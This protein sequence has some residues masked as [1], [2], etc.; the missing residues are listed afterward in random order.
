MK[1]NKILVL[2][3]VLL[4][5]TALRAEKL[6]RV[7]PP[8]WWIGMET[9]LQL[10]LH[11]KDIKDA[12]VTVDESVK[13]LSI[14]KVT[15]TDNS[16]Y[17]FV[18]VK[19]GRRLNPGTYTFTVNT[20]D[21]RKIEF[22]YEF[23]KRRSYSAR[24]E[25][26]GPADAVYLLMPDRFAN[27]DKKNDSSVQTVEKADPKDLGGRHGGDIQGIIDHLDDIASLGAT[28][29]WSTP[30]LLDDEKSYSYHGYACADYYRIDPRYGSN[31]LYRKFVEKAHS[32]DLKVIMDMVPN[33]CGTAHWWMKDLPSKNWINNPENLKNKGSEFIRSNA[34]MSTQND[35]HVAKVDKESCTK[36]WFDTTMPDMNLADPLVRQYLLQMAV[37]WVEW[38]DLDG[39][40]VDTFPYS[41]ADGIAKWT[42]GIR[43]EYRN[44]NIVGECW[45]GDVASCSYWEGR[46]QRDGYN[47]HLPSVMD[48]P[49]MFATISAL[50]A[51]GTSW[52]PS[53]LRIYNSVAL[54]WLYDDPS[55]ILVFMGNHD[56]PRLAHELGGDPDKIKMA[57][58]LLATMRGVPQL[59]YGDEYGLQSADGTVGHS[60][61]RVDMPWGSFTREQLA[62]RKW[63]A[64]L[65][66]WRKNSAPVTKGGLI[67]FRPDSR[68]VYVYFRTY[69][70]GSVMVV[71]NGGDSDYTI[72]WPHFKEVTNKFPKIGKD[73]LG[74]GRVT[75]G[76]K[77]V[78]GPGECA[79]IEF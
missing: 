11:G 66:T 57:Y 15:S 75:V 12:T 1:A 56:T 63:I 10:M 19:V 25:S 78:V 21:G 70:E 17:L 46:R 16:N 51:D 5:A 43:D 33:H 23:L 71:L 68:N 24:R 8:C 61:E 45:F 7:E 73:V 26:F 42:K 9:D 47:S 36:G 77:T 59:Y 69:H 38:A 3:M 44:I 50:T 28:A 58:A 54:D 37:W 67:H 14:G 72:D 34:A 52:E 35:P 41:D 79:I 62:L 64:D 65:F 2:L 31:E 20:R 18:E 40:R 74:G 60:Q 27:G 29:I 30:L 49:L 53:M 32:K 55:D 39:I 22:D 76:D 13:G 6:D 4:S 48:F